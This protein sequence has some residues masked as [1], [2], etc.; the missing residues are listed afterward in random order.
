VSG[1]VV[2]LIGA[3]RRGPGPD[4]RIGAGIGEP[5]RV[6]VDQD[7]TVTRFDG[8]VD[9]PD[10]ARPERAGDGSADR[11]PPGAQEPGTARDRSARSALVVSDVAVL[12]VAV[13]DVAVSDVAVSDVA[14]SD[15][16]VSDVAVSDVAVS[17]VAVSDVAVSDV[18]FMVPSLGRV[19]SVGSPERRPPPV[20]RK[21]RTISGDPADGCWSRVHRGDLGW[22]LDLG[23][24]IS[25]CWARG[26]RQRDTAVAQ[27]AQCAAEP[28]RQ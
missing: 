17:D 1:D 25:R 8:R 26:A 19:V 15:V 16:A 21:L 27:A 10:A 7:R 22:R 9:Q 20:S 24:A 3:E 11:S 5:A 14:V 13:S 6:D 12:D 28:P 4:L 18:M 23:G 2:L